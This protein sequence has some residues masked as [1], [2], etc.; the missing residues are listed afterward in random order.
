[1]GH[2]VTDR[3]GYI[4]LLKNYSLLLGYDAPVFD[5]LFL[6]F[7]YFGLKFFKGYR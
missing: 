6:Y 5:F 7:I 4:F 1:M 2:F 3:F